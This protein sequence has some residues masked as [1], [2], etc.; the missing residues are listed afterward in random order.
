M[1]NND[2][3]RVARANYS[4]YLTSRYDELYKAYSRASEK[5]W[6]A[7]EYC[8]GLCYKYGGHGLRVISFNTFIFTA[9]FE[10]TDAETGAAMFCYITPSY[11]CFTEV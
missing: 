3:K 1:T 9:G 10:Y 4:R 6:S 8:K 5:K 11:D 2:K 7:W